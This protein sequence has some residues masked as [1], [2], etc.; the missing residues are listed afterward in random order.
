MVNG[1]CPHRLRF[2]VFLVC[3]VFNISNMDDVIKLNV[4]SI[5]QVAKQVAKHGHNRP[6]LEYGV[7]PCLAYCIRLL[8]VEQTPTGIQ[9][10]LR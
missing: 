4:K 10:F 9:Q 8:Q 3:N 5:Q 7:G 2:L 6:W 1:L